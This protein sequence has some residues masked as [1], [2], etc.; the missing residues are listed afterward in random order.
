MTTPKLEPPFALHTTPPKPPSAPSTS[1]PS[2]PN[3]GITHAIYDATASISL[4]AIESLPTISGRDS[5]L[6]LVDDDVSRFLE[7]DLDLSRLNVIHGHLWMAGRPMR[8]RPLHRQKM[9][10]FEVLP[11]QQMDLHLLKFSNKVILKPLQEYMLDY[12]FWQ[13]HISVKSE[14]YKSA[15]GFLL[16]YVW[17]ITSP[18]DLKI[19]HELFLLPPSITWQWW[20]AFVKDFTSRVDIVALHQVNKRFLFGELRL[21]RIN[22]IY[23]TR[24]MRT[25]F[26]RGYLYGYNRYVV[27]FQRK[28]GWILVVFVFFSLVLAAMQV[29]AAV[30]PL[31]ENEAFLNVTYVFVVFSIVSVGAVLGLVGTI[32]VITFVFNMAAAILH[33]KRENRKWEKKI[34][35]HNHS[36]KNA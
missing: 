30:K 8:A 29:G 14:L 17:L 10:G 36:D 3:G 9:M 31:S 6:F 11:T 23:R 15:C 16:S 7:Q 22:S 26:V 2:S 19:A 34:E 24:F 4:D 18:I 12:N 20:K 25:H 33:A 13:Q 35:D 5:E 21:G 27:F 1:S 32:F 28:F